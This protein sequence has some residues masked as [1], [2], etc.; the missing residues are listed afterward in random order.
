MEH[1]LCNLQ[2]ITYRGTIRSAAGRARARRRAAGAR[3]A[4]RPAMVQGAMVELV[5][6]DQLPEELLLAI[7]AT[8]EVDSRAAMRCVSRSWRV[9]LHNVSRRV[10][11]EGGVAEAEKVAWTACHARRGWVVHCDGPMGVAHAVEVAVAAAAKQEDSVP[12]IH[13]NRCGDDG[14]AAL[15]RALCTRSWRPKELDLSINSIGNTAARHLADGFRCGSLSQLT[16]LELYHNGIL[17]EGGLDIAR[18]LSLECC[19]LTELNLGSNRIMDAGALG[20]A[21]ALRAPTACRLRRLGLRRN[22]ITES[23]ATGLARALATVSA[24]DSVHQANVGL[25]LDLSRNPVGDVGALELLDAGATGRLRVL[26]LEMVRLSAAVEAEVEQ[27]SRA[28][29]H[30]L[31]VEQERVAA[32]DDCNANGQGFT[33]SGF[34]PFL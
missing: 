23:G 34:V 27:F 29:E 3:P 20:L 11:L 22:C 2:Y 4:G 25:D 12:E 10:R 17:S 15:C 32:T 9:A 28:A 19:S 1:Q 31:H 14:V 21:T 7:S 26:V 8:V 24:T 5:C 13:W 16:Y 6:W 33:Q 30:R 18:I